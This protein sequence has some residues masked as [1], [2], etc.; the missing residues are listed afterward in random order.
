MQYA[1]LLLP[2][3]ARRSSPLESGFLVVMCVFKDVHHHRFLSLFN[4]RFTS[5]FLNA[6]ELRNRTRP[7][8]E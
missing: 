7:A 6:F 5:T 8:L 1:E 2:R 4:S 3:P